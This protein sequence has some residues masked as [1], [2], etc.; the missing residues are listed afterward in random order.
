MQSFRANLPWPH[1]CTSP[2]DCLKLPPFTQLLLTLLNIW[3]PLVCSALML[4]HLSPSLTPQLI[5][6][7]SATAGL[8]MVGELLPWGP[9]SAFL[10]TRSNHNSVLGGWW[11]WGT[12]SCLCCG[13]AHALL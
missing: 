7:R 6:T 8:H 9:G 3:Q 12:F 11:L 4:L 13:A 5:F 10:Y 2:L 1:A